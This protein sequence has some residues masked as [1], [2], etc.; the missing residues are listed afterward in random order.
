MND[1]TETHE[2]ERSD[3]LSRVD[4]DDLVKS[5]FRLSFMEHLSLGESTRQLAATLRYLYAYAIKSR[6]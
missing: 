2:S 3:F 6:H 5:Q 1:S 4:L